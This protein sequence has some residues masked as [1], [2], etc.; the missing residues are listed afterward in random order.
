V[1][2]T[3]EEAF[4]VME[5]MKVEFQFA[6]E[7]RVAFK[8]LPTSR[9]KHLKAFLVVGKINGRL[10][11]RI[12]VDVR[13]TLNLIPHKYFRKLGK[14]EEEMVPTNVILSDLTGDVSDVKGA[15][16]V[17]L[18]IGSRTFKTT[19][20][21]IDEDVSYNL[22]LGQDWIHSTQCMPSSLHQALAFWNGSKVEYVKANHEASVM[23]ANLVSVSLSGEC[24]TPI[25]EPP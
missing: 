2:P 3:E 7:E 13:A 21:I 24:D 15:V 9:A 17:D 5:T 25:I 1:T 22:L 4:E 20:L 11:N 23:W 18:P 19:F 10:V 6:D 12:L 8:M 14:R 16:V